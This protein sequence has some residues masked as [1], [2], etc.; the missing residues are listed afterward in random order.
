MRTGPLAILTC[1]LLAGL[2]PAPARAAAQAAPY[3][4]V[5][6]KTPAAWALRLRSWVAGAIRI[7]EA[8]GTT[9][10]ANLKADGDSYQLESGKAVDIQILPIRNN[11]AYQLIIAMPGGTPGASIFFSLGMPKDPPSAI[12]NAS[13][14]VRVDKAFFGKPK[15]GTFILIQ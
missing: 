6:N 5:E 12:V 15:A 3:S 14:I 1:A 10:L 8:G 11:L 4:R 13:P 7:R 9:E 2:S